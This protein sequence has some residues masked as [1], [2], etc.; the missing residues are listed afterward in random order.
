MEV[1]HYR[2]EDFY[3]KTGYEGGLSVIQVEVLYSKLMKRRE[4]EMQFQAALNGIQLQESK[5]NPDGSTVLSKN[6]NKTIPG[7][8]FEHPTKYAQLSEEERQKKTKEM[9]ERHK[10]WQETGGFLKEHR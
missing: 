8:T 5:P 2:L 7:F 1:Y 3:G 6:T 4:A 9:M 10:H